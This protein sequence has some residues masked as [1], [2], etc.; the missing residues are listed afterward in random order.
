MKSDNVSEPY[1]LG[2][3]LVVEVAEPAGP[4]RGHVHVVAVVGLDVAHRGRHEI[5]GPD[6]D[7]VR[8][9]PALRSAREPARGAP[10][11]KQGRRRGWE[12]GR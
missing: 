2:L 4:E 8:L 5:A 6:L 7:R 11:R 1:L 12:G 3:E 10:G 9:P